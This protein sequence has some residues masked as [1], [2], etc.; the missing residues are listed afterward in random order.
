MSIN[1]VFIN[2]LNSIGYSNTE[3][4]INKGE[5]I[6]SLNNLRFYLKLE[7]DYDALYNLIDRRQEGYIDI[8]KFCAMFTDH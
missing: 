5:F 7:N 2:L 3:A 6:K 8:V 1:E 4:K